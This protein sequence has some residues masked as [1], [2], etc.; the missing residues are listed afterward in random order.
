MLRKT[1]AAGALLVFCLFLVQCG[2]GRDSVET[3]LDIVDA[4]D[5][6][7]AL[8]DGAAEN[9]AV[10]PVD[11]DGELDLVPE[12]GD[13][14]QDSAELADHGSDEIDS[15]DVC[16]QDCQDK[17]CGD[18]GCGGTCG[19]CG[20][21]QPCTLDSCVG[22]LCLNE[23]VKGCCDSDDD[24]V[25]EWDC[26]IDVCWISEGKETGH[27]DSYFPSPHC[28][29][30][31]DCKPKVCQDIACVNC[32]CIWSPQEDCCVKDADCDE[33]DVCETNLC[34]LDNTCGTL[35]VDCDDSDP[36]SIDSCD[37]ET[38]DC[39]HCW[40]DCDGKDCGDDGCNGTCGKCDD[41]YLCTEDSCNDLTGKCLHM[42]A[43]N[44]GNL[45]TADSC[46]PETGECEHQY[47]DP[48]DGNPCTEDLC[49]C[50]TGCQ[51]LV[52]P[53]GTPCAAEVGWICV[54]ASCTCVPNCQGKECG[55]DGCFGSCGECPADP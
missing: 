4:A 41:E 39:V 51:N 9:G 27:C 15:I 1:A 20:D 37:P 35:P 28:G 52:L 50:E 48:D 55:D 43:C 24:C 38:G 2:T 7:V 44:D 17:E 10:E 47:I 40:P 36:I 26:T 42:F 8:T 33:G 14:V 32:I 22:G 11:A 12:P 45:C 13:V 23:D 30:P 54:N 49:D 3:A 53:D 31:D 18:N 29:T 34:L 46:D 16:I 6:K 25:D 5:A 19:E 21:D